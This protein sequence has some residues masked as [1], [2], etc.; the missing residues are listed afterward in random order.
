VLTGIKEAAPKYATSDGPT[1]VSE[2]ILRKPF[3]H[4]AT[5]GIMILRVIEVRFGS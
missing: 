2:N 5:G 1:P 3:D 4:R